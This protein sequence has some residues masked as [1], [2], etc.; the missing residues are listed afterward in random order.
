[1]KEETIKHIFSHYKYFFVEAINNYI[2]WET[3]LKPNGRQRPSRIDY[4]IDLNLLKGID[5]EK[6]IKETENLQQLNPVLKELFLEFF[7]EW[8]FKK[9]NF[10]K[11]LLGYENVNLREAYN[12]LY[13]ST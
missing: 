11:Q 2:Y 12:K 9:M 3:F 13:K 1:M 10:S 7:D 5:F 4:D 8:D 6:E